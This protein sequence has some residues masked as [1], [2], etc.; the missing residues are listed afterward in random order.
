[1]VKAM[2]ELNA[3]FASNKKG[4]LL[5]IAYAQKD[6]E[7]IKMFVEH[8]L[9][10]MNESYMY[11][12]KQSHAFYFETKSLLQPYLLLDENCLVPFEMWNSVLHKPVLWSSERS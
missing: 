7:M 1:M 4:T 12:F 10:E 9:K 2:L 11:A 3:G 8:N 5:K 6:A